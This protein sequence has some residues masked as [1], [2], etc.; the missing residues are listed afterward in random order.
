VNRGTERRTVSG[1]SFKALFQ[2]CVELGQDLTSPVTFNQ[3]AEE[4]CLV[5][6]VLSE[7]RELAHM[8]DG[9]VELDGTYQCS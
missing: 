4:F 8:A 7:M 5:D 6:G 1:E 2:S 3:C 9:I